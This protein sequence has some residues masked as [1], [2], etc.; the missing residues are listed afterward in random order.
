[1]SSVNDGMY[2]DLVPNGMNDGLCHAAVARLVPPNSYT[3]FWVG[4]MQTPY[5]LQS[6]NTHKFDY[7]GV[8]YA[9]D[10]RWCWRLQV[11]R[12]PECWT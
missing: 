12:G 3:M 9:E 5:Q 8:G 7:P 10:G 1:M 6:G 11:H 4:H 2:N